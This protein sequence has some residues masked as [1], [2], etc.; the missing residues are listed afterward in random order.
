MFTGLVE[1]IGEV[2]SAER[3]AAGLRLRVDLKGAA[4]GVA[5]GD[6][7]NLSGACQTVAMIDRRVAAFDTVAETLAKTTLN[8]WGPGTAV[9]VERSLRPGDRLGGHFVAGHVDH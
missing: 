6:S 5:A 4:E 1:T 8:S 7:V 2:V 3:T 9:N